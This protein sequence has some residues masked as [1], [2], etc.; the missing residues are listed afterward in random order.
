MDTIVAQ[1]SE[2]LMQNKGILVREV[3]LIH[4]LMNLVCE[5]VRQAL[6]AIDNQNMEMMKAKGYQIDKRRPRTVTFFFGPVT[7]RRRCYIKA[8]EAPTYLVD[9]ILGLEPKKRHS[10]YVQNIFAQASTLGV[11]RKVSEIIGLVSHLTI[12]HQQLQQLSKQVGLEINQN[13]SNDLRNNEQVGEKK[14]AI[15]YIEGDAFCVGKQGGGQLYLHR[16]Q[17]CEGRQVKGTKRK[18]QVQTRKVLLGYKE[19]IDLDREKAFE[20]MENYLAM[21]YDLSETIV[22]TNSDEG[23]GYQKA[24]FESLVGSCLA[25]EHFVDRYHVNKKIKERLK[26]LPEITKDFQKTLLQYD[27]AALV[28]YYDTLESLPLTSQD[29]E[30]I[31]LLQAYLKR[32]WDYL[33]PFRQRKILKGYEAVIGTCESHHRRFTYRMK[34]QGRRWSEAGALAMSKLLAAKHN[35][36]FNKYTDYL[37]LPEVEAVDYNW[38]ALFRSYQKTDKECLM[39]SKR[40]YSQVFQAHLAPYKLR[41]GYKI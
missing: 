9:A 24:D 41:M 27:E 32:N 39:P 34:K 17:V 21:T 18:K 19:F 5:L 37:P 15:L 13:Q 26:M 31:R 4:F 29:R 3:R 6:E 30:E 40:D 12:S 1:I 33:K 25:H 2:I 28:P 14:V 8:G 11:F 38:Q 23:S 7:Y 35:G 16:L 10:R 22:V 36:D 20:E